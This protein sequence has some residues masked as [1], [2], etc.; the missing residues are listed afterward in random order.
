MNLN[1]RLFVCMYSTL[2]MCRDTW[3][4]WEIRQTISELVGSESTSKTYSTV[5]G[6]SSPN[7]QYCEETANRFVGR[8]VAL[9]CL[10][11]CRGVMLRWADGG[12]GKV[13]KYRQRGH[14]P[15]KRSECTVG[16]V[17]WPSYHNRT[18]LDRTLGVRWHD[19]SVSIER[20][21][22]DRKVNCKVIII[23]VIKLPHLAS[24]TH[25]HFSAKSLKLGQILPH[26]INNVQYFTP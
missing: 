25:T 6:S 17:K 9:L 20:P 8:C 23:I 4:W 14:W 3:Y 19:L 15:G 5:S 18:I 2:C 22:L 12:R 7:L 24:K 11:Y 16:K 26:E 21:N 13:M 1:D 10:S